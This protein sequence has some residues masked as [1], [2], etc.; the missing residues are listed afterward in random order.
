[1]CPEIFGIQTIKLFAV[2]GIVVVILY[3][4]VMI[5]LEWRKHRGTQ[6]PLMP[7]DPENRYNIRYY[8]SPEMRGR[9][10]PVTYFLCCVVAYFLLLPSVQL[11]G[12]LLNLTVI[13]G[14]LTSFG[15]DVIFASGEIGRA[16][17]RERV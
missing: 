7:Q 5:F 10:N 12:Y 13:D 11:S 15:T 4:I 9:F 17:C 6:P 8:L 16:S 14:K 1:M 2:L 3:A